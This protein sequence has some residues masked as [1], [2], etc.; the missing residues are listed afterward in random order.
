MPDSA[1]AFRRRHSYILYAREMGQLY[2]LRL[3]Q[4]RTAFTT[5]TPYFPPY[6]N[7]FLADMCERRQNLD[8][9]EA[10]RLLRRIKNGK[11]ARHRIAFGLFEGN[12]AVLNRVLGALLR[13]ALVIVLISTPSIFL[14][15]VSVDAAPVVALVA[16]FAAALTF[17]E[18]LSP[19]PGLVE[20]RNAPPFNRIR[21][22]AL[23]LTVLF[24]T[25]ICRGNSAP[26]E[27]TVFVTSVGALI[28]YVLDFP[29]SPVNLM[30]QALPAG[31]SLQEMEL[32]REVAGM[33]Y[34]ISLV[35]LAVFMIVIRISHWPSQTGSF[36]VW[37]NL[38]T[39]D[40]TAGGDVVYRL[41]RDARINILFGFFLP[42]IVPAVVKL[43]TGLF[44]GLNVT[45][46][47]SLI[48]TVAAWAFLPYS[49]FMRGIA[50]GRICMM[51]E[52][53]RRQAYAR[54]DLEQQPA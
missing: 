34:L 30:V 40:P 49:L 31:A 4:K 23:F 13:A 53:K 8:K 26:T 9:I 44:G 29:Y 15:S 36:N 42:F 20:F 39:F 16:L 43:A 51:I 11:R 32:M 45:D 12:W 6:F 54:A 33:S 7:L 48:W 24:L 3:M 1:G 18:Y 19:Y 28:G 41:K 38:P 21:F 37:V 22:V 17:F 47:Q 52:E 35:S 10:N 14:P 2:T 27:G 46:Y 5:F 25:I 50:M